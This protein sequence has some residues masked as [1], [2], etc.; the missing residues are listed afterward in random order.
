MK[1]FLLLLILPY[2]VFAKNNYIEET[3]KLPPDEGIYNFKENFKRLLLTDVIE[4]GLRRNFNEQ[5][6]SYS[7]SLLDIDFKDTKDNFWWP[8]LTLELHTNPQK[9]G[10]M[11]T[12][13]STKDNATSSYPS[14]VLELKFEDYNLFNW[15]KDYLLYL[16]D[17]ATYQRDK[18]RINENTRELKHRLIKTYFSV[19]YR[20]KIVKTFRDQL[21]KASFVY[22]L[23]REKMLSK[24]IN[25]Q[26][27]LQSRSDFLR[28]QNFYLTAKRE[29]E[30]AEEE[31]ARSIADLPGSRYLLGDTLIYKKVKIPIKEATRISRNN[32]PLVLDAK[33]LFENSTR[34]Y[35]FQVRE[36]L[37]LPKFEVKLGSYAFMFGPDGGRGIYETSPG[38]KNFELVASVNAVWAI[39]GRDGLFNT[40]RLRRSLVQNRRESKNLERATYII[41]SGIRQRYKMLHFFERQIELGEARVKTNIRAYDLILERYMSKKT[42]WINTSKSLEE[43]AKSK[44]DL[45]LLKFQHL[46]EKVNLAS[47]IGVEDFPGN[48]FESLAKRMAGK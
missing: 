47:I 46:E 19:D 26:D 6:R 3:L 42:S 45:D 29:S 7:S 44:I 38:N 48:N 37:P 36:N 9:I 10:K 27:F 18:K 20:Q 43:L 23:N 30:F 34:T 40:R 11:I 32:S 12:S 35:E 41:D 33:L 1:F 5:I 39:T 8:R 25:K 22:R 21:Q 14:G 28:I 13:D 16:N 2:L 4:R 31:L 17:K 24:K 15:G